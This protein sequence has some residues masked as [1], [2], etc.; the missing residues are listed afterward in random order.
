MGYTLLLIVGAVVLVG[1]IV[2]FMSG[3]RRSAGQTQVGRGDVTQ[4][5][6]AADEPNP[7]ASSTASNSQS[8]AAQTRTPPA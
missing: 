7:A 1:V 3:R 5:Q 2:L 8:T 4:K 6:P